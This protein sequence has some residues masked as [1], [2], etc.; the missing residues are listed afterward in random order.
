VRLPEIQP[1]VGEGVLDTSIV[2]I[3]IFGNVT[4]AGTADDLAAAIGGLIRAGSWSSTSRH[5]MAQ[6]RSRS[7]PSGSGRSV[8]CRSA[9]PF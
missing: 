5:S 4:L 8:G 9:H 3:M 2:S 7:G 1:T 6:D